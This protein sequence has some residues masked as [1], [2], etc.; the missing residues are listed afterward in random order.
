MRSA[1]RYSYHDLGDQEAGTTV[2]VRLNGGPANVILLDTVN[3]DLYRTG[4]TFSYIGGHCRRPTARLTIPK[5]GRWYVVIDLGGYA[6]RVM[7]TVEVLGPDGIRAEPEPA[8]AT[9]A[10]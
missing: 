6:R 10:T 9:P 8:A 4:G 2:S 3:F 1:I 5:S 7:A